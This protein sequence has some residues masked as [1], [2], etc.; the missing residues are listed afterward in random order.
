MDVEYFSFLKFHTFNTSAKI[1]HTRFC[2]LNRNIIQ[3]YLFFKFISTARR[4]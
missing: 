3:V 1:L 2:K 4:K